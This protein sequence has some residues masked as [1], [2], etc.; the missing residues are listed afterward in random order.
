[1][2]TVNRMKLLSQRNDG[3]MALVLPVELKQI[4]SAKAKEENMNESQWVKLAI[5]EKLERDEVKGK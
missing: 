3:R 1:M 4:L 5:I 2:T